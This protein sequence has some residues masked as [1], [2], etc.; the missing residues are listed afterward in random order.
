MINRS[1]TMYQNQASSKTPALVIFLLDVS[2]SMG[3]PMHDGKSRML[4]VKDALKVVITE[5]VQRSIKQQKISP[6]YR[7]GMVAY[8]DDVYDI[9]SGVKP[10]D[11]VAQIGIPALKPLHRTNTIKGFLYVKKILEQEIPMIGDNHPAPLVIHM[12]DGESTCTED[13]EP[14]VKAIQEIVVPD[15]NVLVENVFISEE[16]AINNKEA[17]SWTGF[18][19]GDKTGNPYG[20]RLLAM[21]S[22]LPELYWRSMWEMEYSI[23][24]D[25]LMMYPGV[26]IEFVQ[27]AFAM[28]M[29]SDFYHR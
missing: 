20:D 4:V 28:S 3:R 19:P 2:G 26:N 5:M 23:E 1:T 21:S 9:L 18:K 27:L 22:K 8:S 7:I 10:V 6:R 25:T 11:E 13:P 17:S 16:L 14:V 29:G 12:T 24:K 15:G